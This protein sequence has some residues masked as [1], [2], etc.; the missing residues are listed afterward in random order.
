MSSPSRSAPVASAQSSHLLQAFAHAHGLW[1]LIIFRYFT[2]RF[3][4]YI[5]I[6]AGRD[7][8]ILAPDLHVLLEDKVVDEALIEI[9]RK[10]DITTIARL[11][12]HEDSRQWEQKEL[13]A[14]CAR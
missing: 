13:R 1:V 11:S 2:M 6:M 12:L 10:A 4:F 8:H 9:L 5:V 7:K 3:V 14:G